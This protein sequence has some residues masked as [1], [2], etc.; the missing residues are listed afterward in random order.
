MPSPDLFGQEDEQGSVN[1]S[2]SLGTLYTE[3]D[4]AKILNIL[5]QVSQIN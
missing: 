2:D 3:C 1:E 5:D 4:W